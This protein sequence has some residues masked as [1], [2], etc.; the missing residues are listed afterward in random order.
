MTTGVVTV[1]PDTSVR[2][3]AVKFREAP[4]Q[5]FP[6]TP[7]TDGRA[8]WCPG[9]PVPGG[10]GGTTAGIARTA[11]PLRGDLMTHPRG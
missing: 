1:R 7:A 9:R 3:L 10:P 2:E 5:R 4:G 6:V 11:R 8:A